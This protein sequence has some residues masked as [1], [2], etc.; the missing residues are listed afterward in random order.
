MAKFPLNFSAEHAGA[1]DREGLRSARHV[2]DPEHL[3][4][5]GR[6]NDCRR[7]RA[8]LPRRRRL[9]PGNALDEA[10][11]RSADQER[12]AKAV[13]QAEICEKVERM[14]DGL[15]EAEARVGGDLGARDACRLRSFDA[16]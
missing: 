10:L 16:T 1:P 2:M 5:L 8:R 6:G 14:R 15:A 3:R 7:L 11:P 12:H 9:A 4:A 13:K